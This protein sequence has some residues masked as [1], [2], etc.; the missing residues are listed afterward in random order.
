VAHLVRKSDGAVFEL[1]PNP[2]MIGRSKA[3]TISVPD[4]PKLSR[5]HCLI[6]KKHGRWIIT[7][8]DSSN[9]LFVNGRRVTEIEL[10]HGDVIQAGA[11]LFTFME[12]EE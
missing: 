8:L 9:G 3:C 2:V 12:A 7:D 11:N 1:G 10:K 5:T 6:R 4:D